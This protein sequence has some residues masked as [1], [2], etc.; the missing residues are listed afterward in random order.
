[1]KKM[2]ASILL[3]TTLL[4]TIV[5]NIS[6]AVTDEQAQQIANFAEKFITKGLEVENRAQT[7]NTLLFKRR[8][9]W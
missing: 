5:P 6:F 9:V 1:M 3:I 8:R 2:I 7:V 4:S